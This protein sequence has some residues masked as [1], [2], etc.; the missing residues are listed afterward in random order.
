MNKTYR[1]EYRRLFLI[2]ELPEPLTR[3]SSHLQIFDNYI[4]NTRLR[5]RSVRDPETK[6]WNFSMQ[7]QI[8]PGEDLAHLK[9]AEIHLD[10]KEH[11]V[12]ES[13]EE[14]N[15]KQNERVT[16]NEIRKN[17]YFFDYYNRQ[18][19]IDVFLGDLWGL[20][21]V[22]T[23]FKNLTELRD[24]SLPSFAVKE[25]TADKFFAGENLV[26]KILEDIT[27]RI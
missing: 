10:E 23:T 22:K 4:K 1:E 20:N 16:T 2:A 21:L 6:L 9:Y 24:Y 27:K 3:A 8:F 15:V 7:Q 11:Q 13:F 26:G 25:I 14:R 18:L 5:L 17:R 12:F 19:E